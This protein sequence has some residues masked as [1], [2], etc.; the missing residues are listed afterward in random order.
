MLVP[1]LSPDGPSSGDPLVF[2]VSGSQVDIA[3]RP[4]FEPAG[5]ALFVGTLDGTHVWAVEAD[6][7]PDPD[8]MFV[9]LMSLFGMVDEPTWIAAGRAVQLVEWDRNHRYCGR[10][11]AGTERMDSERARR[12][13][14][15]AL[16]AFPRLAPAVITLVEREDGRVLLARNARWPTAMYSCLAGFVEPG[17]TLEAAL[18]REVEEEVGV[19]VGDVR[20]FSSQPWPFPH[21]L[22]VGF[23]A[24]YAGGEITVDGEEISEANWFGPDELPQLPGRIS[25]ARK[26]IDDWLGRTG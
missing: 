7:E 13:P 24:S 6:A 18:R 14:S 4:T 5:P 17:E 22:M 19:R 10:C 11:G 8:L 16:Q 9:D 20:Y 21:S 25:I 15:C 23:H 26:L 12:C 1:A 3:A 2:T